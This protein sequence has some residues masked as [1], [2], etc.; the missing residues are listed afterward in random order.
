MEYKEMIIRRP[1]YA[2]MPSLD[3]QGKWLDEI[4]F[5]P[6][7]LVTAVYDDSCLTLSVSNALDSSSSSCVLQVHSKR[8]R[9]RSRTVL[10]LN[11]FLL[12]RYGFTSYDRVGLV[13]SDG[14]IQINKI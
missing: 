13:L 8:I 3:L 1:R 11:G 6:N 7:T 2:R 4:N 9:G 14:M 12:K 10:S 5:T